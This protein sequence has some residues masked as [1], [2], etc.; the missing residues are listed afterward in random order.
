M[1]FLGMRGTGDWTDSDM[2]PKDYNEAVL[3]LFPNGMAPLTAIMSKMPSKVAT[4]PQFYWWEESLPTQIAT[5]SGVYTEPTLTTAYVSGGVAGDV[6]YFK[7]AAAAES[8][9]RAGHVVKALDASNYLMTCVGR[10]SSVLSNGANSYVAVRLMEDDDNGST[11]DLSDC[12]RLTIIGTASAEGADMP[13]SIAYEPTKLYN[14]T[15]IFRNPL[16]FTRTQLATMTRIKDPYMK[17]KTEALRMHSIEKERA[18]IWGIRT[19]GTGDN[20]K[21]IR[22]TGGILSYLSTNIDDYTTNATYAG[23]AW[24]TG[25]EI[26]LDAQL[27]NIFAYGSEERLALCGNGTLNAISRL[28]KAGGTINLTPSSTSYGIRIVTWTHPQGVLHLKTHPLFSLD[29]VFTNAMLIMDPKNILRRPLKNSDTH[30]IPDKTRQSGGHTRLDG[31]KEEYLSEE[32]I[33]VHHEK[34][35]GLLYGFGTLN[36]VAT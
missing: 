27:Q 20:G 8:E 32:G 23:Q 9:F 13:E 11:T 3:Y 29:P 1:A 24:T 35:F 7:M 2:R 36:T 17:A 26:W 31:I 25:G 21:P 30:F 5:V 15:Q 16:E 4:D 33:E 12:D 14:Y 18:Y 28:A 19:E 6:L 22:T 34:T 10:V